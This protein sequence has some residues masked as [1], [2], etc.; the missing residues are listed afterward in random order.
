MD[1][2]QI[3]IKCEE[4]SSY[5]LD[6][7][8]ALLGMHVSNN[9][10]NFNL[11]T[12]ILPQDQYVIKNNEIFF[13]PKSEEKIGRGFMKVNKENLEK[14][15]CQKLDYCNKV[16]DDKFNDKANLIIALTDVIATGY[17]GVPPVAITSIILKIGLDKYC[18]C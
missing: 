9:P 16:K 13:S 6:T 4:Y 17:I 3:L 7:L 5:E 8:Y 14:L 1:N 15:I 10:R 18:E 2:K 11:I 12:E